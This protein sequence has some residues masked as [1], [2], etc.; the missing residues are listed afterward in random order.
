VHK[1]IFH[2]GLV[3]HEMLLEVCCHS[4]DQISYLTIFNRLYSHY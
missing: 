2:G 1:N 4:R 3:S